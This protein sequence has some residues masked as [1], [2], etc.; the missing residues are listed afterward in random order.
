MKLEFLCEYTAKFVTPVSLGKGPLGERIVAD[1]TGGHFAGP[2]MNGK[3]RASGADWALIGPDG[4]LRLDVRAIFECDDG[5]RIYMTYRAR[6]EATEGIQKA[7]AGGG[8]TEY[9]DNYFMSQIEF[10]TGDERYAW[11]NNLMA[12]GEGK[13][14]PNE[15]TYSVHA[16]MPD[17]K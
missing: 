13:L 15:V 10:E 4:N 11:I 5:A 8:S 3:V 17:A 14:K 12:V 16:L 2:R 6:M 1:L 7:L 9:G